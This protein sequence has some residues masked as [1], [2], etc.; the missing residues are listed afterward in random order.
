MEQKQLNFLWL[1]P[2]V[3][4]ENSFLLPTGEKKKKRRKKTPNQKWAFDLFVR[5]Q[6]ILEEPGKRYLATGCG[7]SFVIKSGAIQPSPCC[8]H[9]NVDEAFFEAPIEEILRA[10]R[11]KKEREKYFSLPM[12][13]LS[14][15][16]TRRLSEIAIPWYCLGDQSLGQAKTWKGKRFTM[17]PCGCLFTAREVTTPR[18]EGKYRAGHWWYAVKIN[19]CCGVDRDCCYEHLPINPRLCSG[20]T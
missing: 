17:E 5:P 8:L 18:Q 19:S 1:L 13:P 7:C 15:E 3:I 20:K 6:R 16:K 12:A 14:V 10:Q 4:D 11:R 9:E 2:S